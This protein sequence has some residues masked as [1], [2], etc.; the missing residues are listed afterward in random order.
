VPTTSKTTFF[1]VVDMLIFW[2]CVN[3]GGVRCL[4]RKEI[5]RI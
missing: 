5:L 3:E 1:L 4:R 2:E